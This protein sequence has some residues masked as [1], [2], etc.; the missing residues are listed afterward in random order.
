MCDGQVRFRK[1]LGGT[2]V[3]ARAPSQNLFLLARSSQYFPRIHVT[4]AP[5]HN[6]FDVDF[7]T[8]QSLVQHRIFDPFS[9]V[10]NRNQ[11]G[12]NGS[13]PEIPHPRAFA[14]SEM[15]KMHAAYSY[16]SNSYRG[17]FALAR[18]STELPR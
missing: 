2:W 18:R 7:G 3:P 5:C 6:H 15:Q 11:G 12:S 10:K 9:D 1:K 8:R 14:F 17:H 16:T 4:Y 13:E